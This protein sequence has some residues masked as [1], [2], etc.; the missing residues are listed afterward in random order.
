L[1]KI[2]REGGRLYHGKIR[3]EVLPIG[4]ELLTLMKFRGPQAL[5]DNLQDVGGPR[6]PLLATLR[7]RYWTAKGQRTSA[8]F[9]LMVAGTALAEDRKPGS[10]SH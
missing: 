4:L 6:K 2:Q 7:N 9:A 8:V 5:A 3:T 1:P 10:V